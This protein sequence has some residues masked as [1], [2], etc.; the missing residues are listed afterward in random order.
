M[1]KEKNKGQSQ[2]NN[3]LKN[4]PQTANTTKGSAPRSE[5]AVND[6][7]DRVGSRQNKADDF[8]ND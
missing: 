1:S 8:A 6:N 2:Q 4:K 3:Q 5:R 7:M